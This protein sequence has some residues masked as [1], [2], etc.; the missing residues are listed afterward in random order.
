MDQDDSWHDTVEEVA[1]KM[2]PCQFVDMLDEP[3]SM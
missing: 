3:R 2:L 1:Q